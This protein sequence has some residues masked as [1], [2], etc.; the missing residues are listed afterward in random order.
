MTVPFSDWP[1]PNSH[2]TTLGLD[3]GGNQNDLFAAQRCGRF[4]SD[5]TDIRVKLTFI[6]PFNLSTAVVI[7]F[8]VTGLTEVNESTA[9]KGAVA[10]SLLFFLDELLH[11]S[12]P[13]L[14]WA[15]STF[16]KSCGS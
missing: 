7:F 4:I 2:S 5:K 14:S 12:P 15:V 10:S 8:L 3:C 11:T 13:P 16:L 6:N 1:G 9:L